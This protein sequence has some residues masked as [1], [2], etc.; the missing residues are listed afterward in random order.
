[1]HM[2]RSTSTILQWS[3]MVVALVIVSGCDFLKKKEAEAPSATEKSATEGM[4]LCSINGEPVITEGEFVNNLNQM[5]QSNPYFRGAKPDA[6]PK[7]LLRKFFDQLTTQALIEKYSLKHN[8][9]KDPE[10]IKAYN[11]TEKL[12]KRSLMVQVFEKKIYD[13]IKVSDSDMQKHYNEN[14]D[15]FVKSAGGVLAM[16]A[17]FDDE[18]SADEF[19]NK[20]KSN[21]DNFETLAKENKSAKFKDFGRVSKEG[22]GFQYEAVPGPVKDVALSMKKLP[23]VEKVKVGKEFWVVKAWDKTDTVFFDL[24]EIKSHI[25]AMLKNNL[26]RD[27]LDKRI[28]DIKGDFNVVVNEEYFKE[29]KSEVAEDETEGAEK[30]TPEEPIAT[31]A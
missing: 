15:R 20:V 1:M 26:F 19:L 31:A 30:K 3:T 9:E 27:A 11:E 24:D 5:I 7:E 8:I 21:M 12:L 23:G 25:E 4:V 13:D 17:H 18:A 16:G 28:K 6:L 10:Y 22:K 2:K 14:K 29:T